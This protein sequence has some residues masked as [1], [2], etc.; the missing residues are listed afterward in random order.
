MKN[1]WFETFRLA[2]WSA[3]LVDVNYRILD[4]PFAESSRLILKGESKRDAKLKDV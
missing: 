3:W 1:R 4:R 2:V